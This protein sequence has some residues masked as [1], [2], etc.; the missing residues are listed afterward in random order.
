MICENTFTV[1]AYEIFIAIGPLAALGIGN[2]WS[3]LTAASAAERV[4]T[5]G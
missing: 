4:Y 5:A 2:P 1:I 3:T